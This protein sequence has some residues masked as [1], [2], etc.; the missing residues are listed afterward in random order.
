[1]AHSNTYKV[2]STKSLYK[3]KKKRVRRKSKKNSRLNSY[4]KR[5]NNNLPKSEVWFDEKFKTHPHYK[6]FKKNA[7]IGNYIVDLLDSSNRIAIEVDG[8]IHNK[9]IQKFK[10]FLKDKYLVERGY[11]VIRVV[12]YDEQSY[13][14]CMT[15]L[16]SLLKEVA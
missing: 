9:E 13:I 1:M 2:L 11:T 3:A 16:E 14:D 6:L 10:D 7:V 4:A 8:S 12:A 5:L 15:K